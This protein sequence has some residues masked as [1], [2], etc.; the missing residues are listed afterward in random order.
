VGARLDDGL[1]AWKPGVRR[2]SF[3]T[4]LEPDRS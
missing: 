4:L 1:S 2:K 3:E